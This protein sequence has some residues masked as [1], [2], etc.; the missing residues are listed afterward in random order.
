MG[1]KDIISKQIFKRILEDVATH[2][3]KL[4][5]DTVELLETEQQRIEDRRA[6]LLAKVKDNSGSI[7]ILHIEIQN[8]NQKDMPDRM[9]RY[10]TDVRLS[11]PGEAV[12]QYLLYIG[13]PILAMPGQIQTPQLQYGYPVIDMHDMDY[14]FF[15][16]QNSPDAIIMAVLCDMHDKAAKTIIH[17]IIVKLI[18]LTHDDSKRLREYLSMLEILASN[19]DINLDIQQE[20][21][22]LQV[23]IE[24]LPSFIMGEAKGEVK[25][26]A[27]GE[28]KGARTNAL[29]IARRL[30]KKNFSIA[31]IAEI[32]GLDI[33]ELIELA[34]ETPNNND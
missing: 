11:Y 9:L 4:Q 10:L 19:R 7:F 33:A 20:F 22:M 32:T 21:K 25:G 18:A 26:E 6:D 2:I 29:M 30:I 34:N 23:E 14:R 31:E 27:K 5:L 17:E 8:Q 15:I 24:K 3:F 13:K 28:A 12:F 16:N 1:Q